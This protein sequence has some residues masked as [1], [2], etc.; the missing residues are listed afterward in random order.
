MKVSGRN[1]LSIWE[2]GTT[3][4]SLEERGIQLP[5][6]MYLHEYKE[7][8]GLIIQIKKRLGTQCFT[9]SDQPFVSFEKVQG[10]LF[11]KGK[12]SRPAGMTVSD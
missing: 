7:N 1:Q 10:L 3:D 4:S 11:D 8:I 2:N 12:N 5:L 6:E 9:Q